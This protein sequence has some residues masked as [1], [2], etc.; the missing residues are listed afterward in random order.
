[1]NTPLA[2]PFTLDLHNV[3]ARLSWLYEEIHMLIPPFS[4]VFGCGNA[5]RRCPDV[6]FLILFFQS[7]REW[8]SLF[9]F[10]LFFSVYRLPTGNEAVSRQEIIHISPSRRP[11]PSPE[12]FNSLSLW[13]CRNATFSCPYTSSLPRLLKPGTGSSCSFSRPGKLF[14]SW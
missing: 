1:M 2:S 6:F 12:S 11:P 13:F 14:L 10:S 3:I 7:G 4:F 5:L 8:P 9:F